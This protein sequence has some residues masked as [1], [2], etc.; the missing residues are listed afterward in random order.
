MRGVGVRDGVGR[1]G[2]LA[3][4]L[5]L[6]RAARTGTPP[7]VVVT[8]PAGVG[9]SELV[10]RLRRRLAGEVTV[11]RAT[12][13]DVGVSRPG[14]LLEACL[15]AAHAAGARAGDVPDGP[16][17]PGATALLAALEQ[18]EDAR[19]VLFV[20][21]DLHRADPESLAT[22]RRLLRRLA[23]LRVM[24]VLAGHDRPDDWLEPPP[25]DPWPADTL[26]LRLG[27]LSVEEV[28]ALAREVDPD[29]TPWTARRLREETGGNPM[30]VRAVLADATAPDL[31]GR[32]RLGRPRPPGSLAAGLRR[33]LARL[34][35]GPRAALEALAVL[36]GP[37][38]V[39]TLRTLTGRATVTEDCAPLVAEGLLE[40]QADETDEILAYG[41][42]LVRDAVYA[43]TPPARRRALHRQAADLTGGTAR[44]RHLVGATDGPDDALADAL[45]QAA[46]T[47]FARGDLVVAAEYLLWASARS[48]DEGT[49]QER[50][51]E[52]VRL[53]VHASREGHALAHAAEI[54]ALPDGPARAELLGLMAFARDE[55][56]ACR[57]LLVA[58]RA[59]TDAATP[60]E[61]VARLDLELA[62]V[63]CQLGDG[64]AG[65]AAARD[66]Q[67][68]IPADHRLV[69][70]ARAFLA[71]GTALV[72]GPAPGLAHLAFLPSS[73]ARATPYELPALT[74]RGVLNGLLG[75]LGPACADLTVVARRRGTPLAHLLGLSAQVHLV[76]CD[77]L[78]GEW[79]AA[80]R[81]LEAGLE[82]VTRH[83]RSFDHAAL[84]SQ[85]AILHAG[86][87]EQDAAR[88]DLAR[89]AE[90]A[91]AADFLGPRV[92]LTLAAAAIAQAER[93]PEDVA[94]GLGALTPDT[95]EPD[96]VRL[97]SG[98]WLPSLV[99]S[100]LDTGRLDAAARALAALD[101]VPASGS[102]LPVARAWLS[103]RLAAALGDPDG[104]RRAFEAGL[105]LPADGGE[106]A[107]YRTRLRHAYGVAL[108]LAGERSAAR[109]ALDAAADAYSRIGAA[110]FLDR[111]L[112]DLAD[113]ADPAE[114]VPAGPGAPRDRW[115]DGLTD[116]E[117]EVTTLVGRGWTNPEIAAE[118]FV[119]TKTV[120][121]H[122]RNVYGKLGLA[123]RRALRDRV[124]QA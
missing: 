91:Q 112:A 117:R 5:D 113:A 77:Y 123:G 122:L 18:L 50:L 12:A 88:A 3:R 46:A 114:L 108:A 48:G 29:V 10:D 78:L 45:A 120:E 118:L 2:E 104:A 57:D 6:A 79:D 7:P 4:L 51:V 15:A 81:E 86:R 115:A 30:Y 82:A 105:A 109:S 87:G 17:R 71:A 68:R 58:A 60:P 101:R 54:E 80:R 38:P 24:A 21:D 44:W 11:V 85:S 25:G 33:R 98:W 103:G 96:R 83:G 121:Y 47:E 14:A 93:R 65:V 35:D 31:A 8:G 124:Q 40:T 73:P 55:V 61:A 1:A 64:E 19:P 74:Q 90:L 9:K 23:P 27:G 63:H 43:G 20:A 32:Y 94:A 52:G 13:P 22:L 100:H 116:R 34:P 26:W 41:S 62:Y 72:D 111:C 49:R 28:A 97:Y 92:H 84:W 75:R 110:P 56:T 119:S 69:P 16:S 95:L 66:A 39:R 42:A 36:G 106:P 76:W 53:L 59:G 70:L 102:C 37:A 89:A 107:W 67:D 99:D